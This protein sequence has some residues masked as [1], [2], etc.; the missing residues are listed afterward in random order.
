MAQ[1]DE[2]KP[3]TFNVEEEL[4]GDDWTQ[5]DGVYEEEEDDEEHSDDDDDKTDGENEDIEDEDYKC[6]DEGPD[7]EA[8]TESSQKKRKIE[9]DNII[10]DDPEDIA[11]IQTANIIVGKRRRKAP[12]RYVDDNFTDLMTADIPD[13][14]IDAALCDENITEDEYSENEDGGVSGDEYEKDFIDD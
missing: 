3:Y 11:G 5:E 6:E 14:E 10:I 12:S 7:A 1:V 8:C 2:V 13:N 9:E 4:E